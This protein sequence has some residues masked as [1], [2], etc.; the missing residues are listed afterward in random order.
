[1][2][3]KYEFTLPDVGEGITDAEIVEWH[4]DVGSAIDEDEPLCEVETDK[5]VVEIPAPCD[6]IVTTLLAEIGE[7]VDV[8]EVLTVIETADSQMSVRRADRAERSTAETPSEVRE[9]TEPSRNDSV[10]ETGSG[11]PATENS[12]RATETASAVATERVFA[13]PSTRRYARERGVDITTLDG[14]GPNNRVLRSDID[15]RLDG[16]HGENGNESV[17][18]TTADGAIAAD[19]D[20]RVAD[21][22][23]E[24]PLRGIEKRMA[25]N[26]SESWRTVP[27]VTAVFEVDATELVSLKERLDAKHEQRITYTAIIVN[28]VVSALREY[29][30]INSSV[31]L[32]RETITEKDYYNI[33]VAVD[34]EYGLVVPVIRDVDQKSIVEVAA[35]L[36]RL[37]EAAHNRDL[38]PADFADGTFTVTNTGTHGEHGIFGTPIINHPEAAILGVNRIRSAPVAVDEEAVEVRKQLWLT[39]SYDHRIIDG[40]TADQFMETVIDGLEDPDILIARL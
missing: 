15:A 36:D 40:A 14:T 21:R 33:G 31:D 12:S 28:G 7:T 5:A 29:P 20:R 16:Q 19:G 3:S 9:P 25:Q 10:A 27:H 34:T 39:L 26:M 11:R 22:T 4:V 37:V 6:G 35:D 17:E 23:V 18:N 32:E 30:D 13:A 8:G 2:S 1:M 38:D 24:R